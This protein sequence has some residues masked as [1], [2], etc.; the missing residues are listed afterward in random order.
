MSTSQIVAGAAYIKLLSDDSQLTGAL[1]KT[2]KKLE[3][4]VSF[5]SKTMQQ[6]D[7]GMTKLR[8]SFSVF[9]Q[10]DDKMRMLRA[11]TSASAAEFD[12]L[13][14][15]AKKLGQ[16]TRFTASQVAE[17]MIEL[18]KLGFSP[19]EINAAIQPMMNLASATGTDLAQAATI[20]ACAPAIFRK[21]EFCFSGKSRNCGQAVI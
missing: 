13:T 12:K 10:F 15:K 9:M 20:A 18:G 21:R 16:E 3:N 5:A 17:G 7:G 6:M 19:D 2:R 1:A 11:V 8:E 4:F 14:G